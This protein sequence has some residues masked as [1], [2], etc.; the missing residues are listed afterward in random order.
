[1]NLPVGFLS[2]LQGL[3]GFSP[4][5]LEE[6]L[7]APR[8][9]AI[10]LHPAK[11]LYA[12]EI[13]SI[14]WNKAGKIL[15]WRPPFGFDPYWH[16][17]CYY[18]QEPSSMFVGYL[19]QELLKDVPQPNVLDLCAAPGGKS[20]DVASVIGNEG[21]LV[22]NEMIRT[23]NARLQ[24]NLI[25]WGIPNYIVT[26]VTPQK[27]ATAGPLFDLVL[28]DAP[29][30]GEGMFRK[31]PQALEEWSLEN[32]KACE[33]RQSEILSHAWQ[34]VK[35]GGYLIYSTCTFNREENENKVSWLQEN[36]GAEQPEILINPPEGVVI[37][38]A[39]GI[40]C[41]RFWPH[42]IQGEGFFCAALN[43]PG[44]ARK[45]D[46]SNKINKGNKTNSSFPP[47]KK[48]LNSDELEGHV[49]QNQFFLLNRHVSDLWKKLRHNI[50][51]VQVGH[52]AFE[53]KGKNW[54]PHPAL[55]FVSQ[56]YLENTFPQVNLSLSESLK[57]LSRSNLEVSNAHREIT[58]VKF[59]GLP[60][61]WLKPAGHRWNNLYPI[62]WRIRNPELI[63]EELLESWHKILKS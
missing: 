14:P 39:S 43:K 19:A 53:L 26:Q 36:L 21:A 51:V 23:R 28:V 32:V 59:E 46:R 17:G 20:T 29:C 55:P 42:K 54:Q 1:M 60:L 33:I 24:E 34:N 37:S 52:P 15:S 57:F 11:G 4:V 62:P 3:P 48:Y 9:Y 58:L 6:A 41:Y 8:K 50:P 31:E 25:R 10:R 47:W 22:S 12:R 61:G 30:S 5:E 56:F 44:E 38:D 40:T 45:T 13:S 27:M 63:D 2:S 18:V 49:F 7:N 16:A 35:P